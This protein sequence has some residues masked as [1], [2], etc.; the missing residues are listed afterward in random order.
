MKKV[1]GENEF[2]QSFSK[3]ATAKS[4]KPLES[5]SGIGKKKL[6]QIKK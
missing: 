2:L 3:K 1:C 4:E 5:A 6:K